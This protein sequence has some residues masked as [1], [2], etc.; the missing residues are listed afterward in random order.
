MNDHHDTDHDPVDDLLAGLRSDVPEMSERSFAST[1]THLLMVIEPATPVAVGDP[2]EPVAPQRRSRPWRSPPRRLAVSAAA[3][4]ALAAGAVVWT[5]VDDNLTPNAAATRLH[6]AADRVAATDEPLGPDQFHYVVS[7]SWSLDTIVL[8]STALHR[9]MASVNETWIPADP[10]LECTQR[11]TG[12]EEYQW[13]VGS[14]EQARELGIDP[15]EPRTHEDKLPCGDFDDGAWQQP[16]TDFLAS[17]PRDPEDLYDRLVDD[18]E[19]HGSDPDLEV[20][21]YAADA[22]RT[23]RVPSEL[24]AALYRALA[25][26]PDLEITEEFANLDGHRGT[27]YGITRSG[28][29]HDV[30]IDPATGQFIGERQIDLEGVTGVPAGTVISYSSVELPVVVDEVG[31]TD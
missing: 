9:L 12:G 22:L 20:L 5:S 17:L 26:V 24:R 19:G 10:S 7:R 23:S 31:E 16:S 2:D 29:R 13:L 6:S 21:V 3:V 14:D 28:T 4:V 15:T 27:A 11:S 1:R 30:I 18:T 25:L 8:R